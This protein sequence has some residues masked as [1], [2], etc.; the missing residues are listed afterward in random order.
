MGFCIPYLENIE[1]I[2]TVCYQFQDLLYHNKLSIL[3]LENG[4]NFIAAFLIKNIMKMLFM[5]NNVFQDLEYRNA[6]ILLLDYVTVNKKFKE[7]G[8]SKYEIYE[9]L[10]Q[11]ALNYNLNDICEHM[12][13]NKYL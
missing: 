12:V 2:N 11:I 1:D 7:L 5:S 6:I 9:N 3:L 8:N 13:K 4:A 10:Y